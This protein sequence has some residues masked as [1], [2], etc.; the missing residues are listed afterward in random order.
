MRLAKIL[1]CGLMALAASEAAPAQEFWRGKDWHE[2]SEKEC[3]KMLEDSPWARS[4][5]H[6]QTYV[7][8]MGARTRSR[9]TSLRLLAFGGFLCDSSF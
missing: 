2:W 3:R 4:F 6:S 1:L 8:V 5:P 7:E 9:E